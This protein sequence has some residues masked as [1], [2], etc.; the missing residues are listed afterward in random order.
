MI[1]I[2]ARFLTQ[3]TTGVQRFAKE[4]SVRLKKIMKDEVHFVAP[5]NILDEMMAKELN[6]QIVGKHTGYFW[7]QV[8]LPLY[9][10]KLGSPILLSLCN[11]APLMYKNNIVAIHDIIWDK[12]PATSS[13]KFRMVY[14]YMIPHLC[15]S[16]RHIITVSNFSK[17]D[18]SSTFNITEKKFTVI[19]NAVDKRFKR[20]NDEA[21][22]RDNYFL[23]VSTVKANKNFQAAIKAFNEFSKSHQECKLYIIG[24][25][26]QKNYQHIDL[27]SLAQNENFKLLGRV[28]D[29]DLIRYYSNAIAFLFPSLYEG[30]GIPPLEAQACECPVISSNSSSLPEVLG[31]SALFFEPH[32]TLTFVTQM[33]KIC[34]DPVLREQQIEKGLKNVRRFSW[35]V[36]AEHVKSILN[37]Y[38]L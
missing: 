24:D 33:E 14:G 20:I 6:V 34:T 18:I 38:K 13:R 25:I 2:N 10:K 28:S 12:Y 30:F 16:A 23:A 11:A 15:K 9:L 37:M 35:D 29:D 32:D 31:D 26:Y 19:Y 4:L 27:E 17:N 36:S 3:P 21:L 7:E 1:V 5:Y 22:K 8:E